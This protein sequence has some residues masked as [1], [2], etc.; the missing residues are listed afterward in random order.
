MQL[1]CIMVNNIGS[2]NWVIASEFPEAELLS[3]GFT[4]SVYAYSVNTVLKGLRIDDFD[5]ELLLL[6]Q[7]YTE[8]GEEDIEQPSE[9]LAMQNANS[10]NNLVVK[11]KSHELV[12]D[13]GYIIAMERLF[14]CLP[15]AFSRAEIA[16]AIDV[17]E[18]ELEELWADGW[19]HCDLRRPSFVRKGNLTEDV[20]Y[21]NI[22][23]TEE[24][25][26]CVI[27]LVDCGCS[28]IKEYDDLGIINTWIAKDREEW[29]LFKQWILNYPRD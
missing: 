21:N 2:I 19:A 29:R 11:Y 24:Q 28:M 9:V 6:W 15:T 23:L 1:L 26:K 17:A 14:P 12:D 3:S 8:N 22:F 5:S 16:A 10:I 13:V 20:L 7:T 18:L 27:R 4:G 25:G